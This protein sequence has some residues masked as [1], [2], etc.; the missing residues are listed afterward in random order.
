MLADSKDALEQTRA[1][2]ARRA[3]EKRIAEALRAEISYRREKGFLQPGA[4]AP[5]ELDAYLARAARLKK[6]FEEVLFL[7]R[8]TEQLDERVQQWM[9]T[10]G[11][12]LGGVVAFAA[13]QLA[14]MLRPPGRVELGWGLAVLALLAGSGYAARHRM[15]HWGHYWLAGKVYRFHA[16]RISRCRVP[17]RRLPT[18]DLLVEA[19]EWCHQSTSSR[20]DP[21]NPE[22]GA[23]LPATHVRYIHNGS[24]LPQS[25]LAAAGVKRVRHIFRYDLS[26]L[27][28]QL[29]DDLK[30]VPVLDEA[31]EVRFVGVPRSYRVPVQVA[32]E[33]EGKRTEERAEIVL[34]KNGLRGVQA[35]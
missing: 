5:A 15:R 23:S 10:I 21:L 26:P 16:Q 20:P 11:A 3:I 33:C 4:L 24:V 35:V 17:A 12:L 32:V 13:V 22:A 28:P 2:P 9:G 14:V 6:H 8:E 7:D 1:G 25:E 30:P 31:G 19:R 34:D 27:F 18:R 29:D